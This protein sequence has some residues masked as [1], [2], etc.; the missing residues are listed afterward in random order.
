[1]VPS[2]APAMINSVKAERAFADLAEG[3][4]TKERGEPILAIPATRRGCM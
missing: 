3:V 4:T 1:M 2:E